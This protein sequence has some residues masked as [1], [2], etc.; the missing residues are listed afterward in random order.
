MMLLG[1]PVLMVGVYLSIFSSDTSFSETKRILEPIDG[2]VFMTV[3]GEQ[4][5]ANFNVFKTNENLTLSVRD[6]LAW[7]KD[8]QL[9]SGGYGAGSHNAQHVRDPLAVKAD[10]A[11][12][13][14]VA[15]AFLRSGNTLK[16]GNY[17][18]NLK[19]AINF[20]LETVENSPSTSPYITDVRNTQIQTKL[21]QNI[22][23]VL[24]AQFFFQAY[25]IVI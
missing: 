22:D 25:W 21:G 2:C 19:G 11:T 18:K 1:L 13:A 4:S 9:P 8:A 20:L 16:K 24:T 6:G 17:A 7:L 23:A 12:T 10:P 5:S 14:M 15:T 3:M